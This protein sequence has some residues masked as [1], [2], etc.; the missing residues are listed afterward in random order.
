[1]AHHVLYLGFSTKVT[2]FM[3]QRFTC[4]GP[5][6]TTVFHLM[7]PATKQKRVSFRGEN[8]YGNVFMM[9]TFQSVIQA[10]SEKNAEF[11]QKESNL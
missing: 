8:V 5:R 4:Y 1:M 6:K 9:M 10:C 3:S 2:G 11:L 7:P